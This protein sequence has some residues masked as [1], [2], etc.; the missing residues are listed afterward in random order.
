[1]IV[2]KQSWLLI[3]TFRKPNNFSWRAMTTDQQMRINFAGEFVV[4]TYPQVQIWQIQR[5]A[6]LLDGKTN[7]ELY[8]PSLSLRCSV[9]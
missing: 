2:R 4:R 7:P 1:M 3:K 5:V 8:S 6:I 9:S